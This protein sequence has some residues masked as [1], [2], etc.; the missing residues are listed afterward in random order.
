MIYTGFKKF[1]IKYYEKKKIIIS[2]EFKIN[3]ELIS[4]FFKNE[5]TIEGRK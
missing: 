4:L 3:I 5:L 1:L 2:Y